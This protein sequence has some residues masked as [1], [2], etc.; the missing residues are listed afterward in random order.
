M[1]GGGDDIEEG[2]AEG[3]VTTLDI[4]RGGKLLL[5]IGLETECLAGEDK[6]F[7]SIETGCVFFFPSEIFNFSFF[8]SFCLT[9]G[10][11]LGEATG[12]FFVGKGV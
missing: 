2:E 1:A 5:G 8:L 9:I 4:R 3:V 12:L 10:L 11:C 6:L 7:I